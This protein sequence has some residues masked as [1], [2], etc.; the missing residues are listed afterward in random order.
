[1]KKMKSTVN[2][3]DKARP[4]IESSA[5]SCSCLD[6]T[7]TAGHG[8]D[9]EEEADNL[10]AL[11]RDSGRLLDKLAKAEHPSDEDVRRLTECF[12]TVPQ[13]RSLIDSIG[14]RSELPKRFSNGVARALAQ[15]KLEL[16][17]RDLQYERA[18]PVERL[19]FDQVLRTWSRLYYVE[20]VL[21]QS[22][23]MSLSAASWWE[24]CLSNAQRRHFA[25]IETLA[26]F[27]RLSRA[28]LLQVSIARDST[29]DSKA[30]PACRPHKAIA[31]RSTYLKSLPSN[32][33]T[34]SRSIPSEPGI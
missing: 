34:T 4:S 17:K 33:P 25:A 30:D 18:T 12:A 31:Q 23:N 3:T 9:G 24:Q 21:D 19:I 1:M 28:T 15:A 10:A 22:V 16:L 6:T 29:Q 26:R 32:H 5:N 13:F 20:S 7:T 8:A 11:R 27:R 2:S 14:H